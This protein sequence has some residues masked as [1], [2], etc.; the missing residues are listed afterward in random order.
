MLD[1]TIDSL[2]IYQMSTKS[3]KTKISRLEFQIESGEIEE[4]RVGEAEELITAL[5]DEL[6]MRED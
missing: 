6:A 5:Q 3:L 2:E 1:L 4:D